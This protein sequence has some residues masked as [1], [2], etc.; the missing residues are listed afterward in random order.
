[1]ELLEPEG[2]GAVLIYDDAVWMMVR[3]P[4]YPGSG[5]KKELEFPGGKF[6]SPKDSGY[7]ECVMREVLEEAG[8]VLRPSQLHTYVMSKSPKNKGV[9]TYVVRL[10]GEQMEE[11]CN[12]AAALRKYA[13][14][15]KVEPMSGIDFVPVPLADLCRDPTQFGGLP[16]RKF[17]QIMLRLAIEAG[18]LRPSPKGK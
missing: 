9:C 12:T 5:G 15:T 13:G 11:L 3:N 6:E 7:E 8:V 17:N 2:A 4:L 1:M 10:S 14:D 18:H 16:V